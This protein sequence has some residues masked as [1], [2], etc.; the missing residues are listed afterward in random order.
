MTS[1]SAGI[2]IACACSITRFK[3]LGRTSR[4]LIAIMPI[5]LCAW[6]CP[7]A[8]PAYTDVISQPAII[9]ASSTALRIESTVAS[10]STT[11]PLRSPRDGCV[12]IPITSI[13][14][15]LGSA[16]TAQI[17][18]VP[19]SS[20]TISSSCLA[21]VLPCRWAQIAQH[22]IPLE[23]QIDF[24]CADV[25]DDVSVRE[26]APIRERSARVTS[27]Y[28]TH[29]ATQGPHADLRGARRVDAG[30]VQA[31][32]A[33]RGQHRQREARLAGEPRQALGFARQEREARAA[34]V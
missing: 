32:L 3:S 24:L 18:V 16:T 5:S 33:R 26:R 7:P 14:S 8:I 15:P 27:D 22:R 25:L 28:E 12:P 11:T 23:A 31:Q 9:S 20:P 19:T 13:V 17:F 21:M 30:E 2:A 10:M 34:G 1:R 4:S 29:G 6:M